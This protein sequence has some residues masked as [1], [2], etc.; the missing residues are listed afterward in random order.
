MYFFPKVFFFFIILS[1]ISDERT[2][3]IN[4][5]KNVQ[6]ILPFLTILKC[7]WLSTMLLDKKLSLFFLGVLQHIKAV[8]TY[9][10]IMADYIT[11]S[12]HS[13]P[14]LLDMHAFMQLCGKIHCRELMFSKFAN[15]PYHQNYT[16]IHWFSSTKF[17]INFLLINTIKL[18]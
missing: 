15:P 1:L 8:I 9:N 14:H 17:Y 12:T 16:K 10:C 2:K 13:I 6:C 7:K 11:F 3:Q 4:G 5:S 18:G